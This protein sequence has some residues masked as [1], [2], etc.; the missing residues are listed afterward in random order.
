MSDL[1][2]NEYGN[3]FIVKKKGSN[4]TF[5]RVKVPHIHTPGP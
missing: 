4:Y 5:E 3:L 1:A 2:D